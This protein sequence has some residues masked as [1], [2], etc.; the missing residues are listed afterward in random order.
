MFRFRAVGLKRGAWDQKR[1][2]CQP[3][4]RLAELTVQHRVQQSVI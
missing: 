2:N 4:T 3:H 1:Q